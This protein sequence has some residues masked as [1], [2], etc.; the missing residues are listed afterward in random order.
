MQPLNAVVKNGR[1]TLN[2]PTDLPEG[3]VVVLLPLEE[4][5]AAAD[6]YSAGESGGLTFEIV[7]AAPPRQWKKPKGVDAAGLIDELRSL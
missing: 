7:P 4:L 3:Q 5:L 2:E 6:G 1:L